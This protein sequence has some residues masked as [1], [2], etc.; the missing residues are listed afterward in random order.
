MK[1]IYRVVET[2]NFCGDYPNESFH[3][4]VM[5]KDAAEQVAEIF[6]KESGADLGG[7]RFYKVVEE[8]YKLQPGFEP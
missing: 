1:R 2:D 8:T 7:D 5:T 3:G 6:N 4:P